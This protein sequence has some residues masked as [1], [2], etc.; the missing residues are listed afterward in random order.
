MLHSRSFMDPRQSHLHHS[1]QRMGRL[2]GRAPALF[3][4]ETTLNN[5]VFPSP[6]DFL[7][8]REWEWAVRDQPAMLAARRAGAVSQSA[9]GN[10]MFQ[11]A[12][13]V[14][15]HRGERR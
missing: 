4:V 9:C 1:A 5:D 10:A 6:F 8:K 2:L 15:H 11:A 7:L 14:R 3:T 12:R 13:A